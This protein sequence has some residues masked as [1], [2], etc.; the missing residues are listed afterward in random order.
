MDEKKDPAFAGSVPRAAQQ[1]E[2]SLQSDHT[3]AKRPKICP[4]AE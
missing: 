3:H 1:N 4:E 2:N